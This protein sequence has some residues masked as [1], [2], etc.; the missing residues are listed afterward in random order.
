MM[1]F[2]EAGRS[3]RLGVAL[4]ASMLASRSV[5]A[6]AQDVT[7]SIPAL[8]DAPRAAAPAADATNQSYSTPFLRWRTDSIR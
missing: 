7:P 1:R 5:D 6:R 2:I 4:L 3:R 8:P